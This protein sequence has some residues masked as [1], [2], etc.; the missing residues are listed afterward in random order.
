ME[1]QFLYD[2]YNYVQTFWW[3]FVWW[4]VSFT[5]IGSTYPHQSL[6][7][8]SAL[9]CCA[10]LVDLIILIRLVLITETRKMVWSNGSKFQRTKN[11]QRLR[12]RIHNNIKRKHFS[13]NCWPFLNG[14]QKFAASV[15]PNGE[16]RSESNFGYD[17]CSR[18]EVL[19]TSIAKEL[20]VDRI[21][22]PYFWKRK[23]GHRMENFNFTKFFGLFNFCVITSGT[24]RCGLRFGC[25]GT[26]KNFGKKKVGVFS[27]KKKKKVI[28]LWEARFLSFLDPAM[29]KICPA[30]SDDLFSFF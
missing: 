7:A 15:H 4:S 11:V 24:L 17:G 5:I 9:L 12:K 29:A 20:W 18:A 13:G 2:F 27:K 30:D 3:G 8:P 22:L 6:W 23:S 28:T 19:I 14:H 16:T 1:Q 26:G 25:R 21:G 10:N